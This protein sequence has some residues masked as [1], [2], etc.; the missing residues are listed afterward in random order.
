MCE[1][2]MQFLCLGIFGTKGKTIPEWLT[3]YSFVLPVEIVYPTKVDYLRVAKKITGFC[4]FLCKCS[5][6]NAK[7]G[8]TDGKKNSTQKAEKKAR[9]KGMQIIIKRNDNV[10][11]FIKWKNDEE[12]DDAKKMITCE[13]G[14]LNCRISELMI[15]IQLLIMSFSLTV[16]GLYSVHV[17]CSLC[18]IGIQYKLKF[19]MSSLR[20]K[21]IQAKQFTEFIF[22]CFP[23]LHGLMPTCGTI[24][25]QNERYIRR[26]RRE[27]DTIPFN[28]VMPR[29]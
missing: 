7:R 27:G 9:T 3:G 15:C 16:H 17:Y 22:L 26:S 4:I 23:L 14:P 2:L 5:T 28:V 10:K 11:R 25:K 8:E 20:W 6:T 24:F 1:K 18:T 29:I 13:C 12:E 19:L 21:T